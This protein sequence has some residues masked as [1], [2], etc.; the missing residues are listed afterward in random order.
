MNPDDETDFSGDNIDNEVSQE[1]QAESYEL[2]IH[3]I[4]NLENFKNWRKRSL[5]KGREKPGKRDYAKVHQDPVQYR[6]LYQ[7]LI[8]R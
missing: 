3:L 5:I 2:P 1:I 6:N 7:Y 8:F 4:N